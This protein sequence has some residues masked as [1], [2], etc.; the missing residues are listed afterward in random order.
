MSYS[1]KLKDPRWQKKRLLILN[2]DKFTCQECA[3]DESTLHVHHIYYEPGNDPWDY[4]DYALVTLC[5][6][7]HSEERVRT[8]TA[9]EVLVKSMAMA[10]LNT[11]MHID[12]L[13]SIVREKFKGGSFHG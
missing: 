7:C 9:M 11:A 5:E 13:A 4:P 2:R 10:G 3:D 8:I 12:Y 1:Q 6:S